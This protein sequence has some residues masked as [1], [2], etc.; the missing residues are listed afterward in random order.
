LGP[1]DVEKALIAAD[2]QAAGWSVR[3]PR[4]TGGQLWFTSPDGVRISFSAFLELVR[5]HAILSQRCK[6]CEDS[7]QPLPADS[8]R[9]PRVDRRY[10]SAKCRQAAYRARLRSSSSAA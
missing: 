3:A 1:R 9:G 5:L 4:F 6:W 2:L 7:M 8:Q 10:C